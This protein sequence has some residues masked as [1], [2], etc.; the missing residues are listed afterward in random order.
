M[1]QDFF[2]ISLID[3]VLFHSYLTF[4]IVLRRKGGRMP[5]A[6]KNKVNWGSNK[7]KNPKKK[8]ITNEVKRTGKVKKHNADTTANEVKI[9]TRDNCFI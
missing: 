9:K 2:G 6:D 1:S 5:S 8:D 7:H 3:L 4:S